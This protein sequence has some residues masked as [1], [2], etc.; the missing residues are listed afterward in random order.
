MTFF[1]ASDALSWHACRRRAWYDVQPGTEPLAPD[2]FERLTM[3]QGMAHEAAVLESLG[4]HVRA[5]D[6]AHTAELMA[7]GAPVIYQPAIVREDLGLI[8]QPD[9]LLLEDGGYR[10]G[11]AKSSSRLKP[12]QAIQ[13]AAYQIA[14][15]S[16]RPARAYLSG[17]AQD[18]VPARALPKARQF[19]ADMQ[20]NV[21]GAPRPEAHFGASRCESCP[22]RGVCVP[23]FEAAGDLGLNPCVDGRSIPGLNAQGIAT[24]AQL[25]ASDPDAIDDVPY[26]KGA[27]KAAAV[28][29][30]RSLVQ[31]IPLAR[32]PYRPPPQPVVHFDV[33]SYPMAREDTEGEVYLWGFLPPPFGRDDFEFVFSDGGPDNDR[34]AWHRF[35]DKVSDYRDELGPSVRFVHYHHFEIQQVRR[36][37]ARYDMGDDP[38]VRWLLEDGLLD[39]QARVKEAFYLPVTGYGLKKICKHRDLV[40]FQWELRESGSQ[41]SVVRYVEYLRSADPVERDAIRAEIL[42]YNRDDVRATRAL[43]LWLATLAAEPA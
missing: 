39:L 43:E 13:L 17:D 11:D 42:S 9:F 8:A 14:F 6:A 22:H 26:L 25:A 10:I 3:E 29:Q 20:A 36:Y 38:R 30:A 34:E 32:A 19:I 1:N 28:A 16:D 4:E 37:A 18:E 5:R 21:A 24:L 41:W 23:E 2:P 35:V 12:E 7:A 31:G 27:A 15:D 40:D 33:E